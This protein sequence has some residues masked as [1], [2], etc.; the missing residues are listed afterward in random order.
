MATT[1]NTRSDFVT[2]FWLKKWVHSINKIYNIL[3][4]SNNANNK[5]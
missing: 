4:R 1:T 3:K 5:Q 2:A